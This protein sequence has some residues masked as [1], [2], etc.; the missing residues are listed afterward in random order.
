[1]M[2]SQLPVIPISK[3]KSYFGV[4]NTLVAIEAIKEFMVQYSL[5]II[6]MGKFRTVLF[7]PISIVE[8]RIF[9]GDNGHL[10]CKQF[11]DCNELVF[12]TEEEAEKYLLNRFDGILLPQSILVPAVNIWSGV[13]E[14]LRTR[15]KIGKITITQEMHTWLENFLAYDEL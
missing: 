11:E 7:H 12:R 13:L 1:M 15:G 14:Y 9:I 3:P 2:P 5:P 10:I 6:R 8:F 4:H